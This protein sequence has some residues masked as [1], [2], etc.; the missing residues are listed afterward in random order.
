MSHDAAVTCG[1]YMRPLHGCDMTHMRQQHLVKKQQRA[2]HVAS[3]CIF[4]KSCCPHITATPSA[5]GLF[6]TPPC[7][8]L[9]TLH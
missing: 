6:L 9:E 4:T 8:S 7:P 5:S 1:H 3:C 2:H